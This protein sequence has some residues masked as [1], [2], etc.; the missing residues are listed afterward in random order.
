[1]K[2]LIRVG[3]I[4]LQGGA[5]ASCKWPW[6]RE[7]GAFASWI[8]AGKLWPSNLPGCTVGV[9]KGYENDPS[10]WI[11]KA[12]TVFRGKGG[13][14]HDRVST[15]FQE[16]AASAPRSIT[17]LSSVIASSSTIGNTCMTFLA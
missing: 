7:G 15:V 8:G 3:G 17:G 6:V 13:R 1:M 5:D 11:V 14:D 9:I 12:R 10:R 2:P 4:C 16:V